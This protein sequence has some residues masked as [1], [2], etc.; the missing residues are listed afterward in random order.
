MLPSAEHQL[1]IGLMC[2]TLVQTSIEVV[3]EIP[4]YETVPLE[5]NDGSCCRIQ[6][7]LFYPWYIKPSE[8]LIII[9]K[10]VKA[11]IFLA[12]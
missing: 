3:L 8:C 12:C 10:A 2:S 11:L 5:V 7:T 6:V 4:L 9:I 1:Q